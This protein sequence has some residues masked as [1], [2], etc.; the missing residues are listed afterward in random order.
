[1]RPGISLYTL[2]LVAL[3]LSLPELSSRGRWRLLPMAAGKTMAEPVAGTPTPSPTP[4]PT[5][6]PSP[7]PSPTPT[8]TAMLTPV[9]MTPI[10]PGGSVELGLPPNR[11]N[12]ILL[13]MDQW[14]IERR[15]RTDAMIL[16]SIDP[17]EPS[18]RMVSIPRDLWV[19]LPWGGEHKLN[20]A[21]PSGGFE[22]LRST[23][24][25]NLGISVDRF[26]AIDFTGMSQLIDALGGVDVLVRYPLYELGLRTPGWYHL[27]GKQAIAYMRSRLTT[28]D[29]HRARRQQQVLRA[30]FRKLR[31][32]NLLPRIP[33]LWPAI[34]RMV[35]TNLS[36]GEVVW[37]A[38]VGRR[39]SEDRIAHAYLHVTMAPSRTLYLPPPTT[40]VTQPLE[41]WIYVQTENTIPFLRRFLTEPLPNPAERTPVE[42]INAT[43]EE[44]RGDI[45]EEVLAE[46]GFRVTRRIELPREERPT[47][48][49]MLREGGGSEAGRLLRALRVSFSRLERAPEP[50]AT[51]PYRIWLGPDFNPSP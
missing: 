33:E 14:D 35:H 43:G 39:L 9:P 21:Y 13:G 44:A 31:S 7:T 51:V 23:L 6:A 17:D 49:I 24:R 41:L 10:A 16:V 30:M 42:L 8:A 4:P 18:V 40:G 3:L 11:M 1:M 34:R 19:R 45:A 38:W 26:V 22:G 15:G 48:V 50:D 47:R 46:A 32:E 29:Y 27:D 2:V 28:S 25:L 36:L 12:I 37:L 20:T 5:L